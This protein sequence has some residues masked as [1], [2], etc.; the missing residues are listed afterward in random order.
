MQR[1]LS[2]IRARAHLEMGASDAGLALLELRKAEPEAPNLRWPSCRCACNSGQLPQAMALAELALK[3]E[4][5]SAEAR[6]ARAW[7]CRPGRDPKAAEA[8]DQVL[9]VDPTTWEA[10]LVRLQMHA[11]QG[12]WDAVRASLK[13]VPTA[14]AADPRV[15]YFHA[16]DAAQRGDSKALTTHLRKIA[17]QIDA[18]PEALLRYR[19]QMLLLTGLA[20][21]GL[22]ELDAAKRASR[23]TATA[24]AARARPRNCWPSSTS[25]QKQTDAGIAALEAHLRARPTDAKAL[26]LLGQAAVCRPAA[27]GRHADARGSGRPG[28]PRV[29]GRAGPEPAAH[30][31]PADALKALQAAVRKEPARI[32]FGLQLAEALLDTGD[33]KGAQARSLTWPDASPLTPACPCCKAASA[34]CCAT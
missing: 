23:S 14:K 26:G 2:L 17:E 30:G 7:C 6:F 19:P 16:Q 29:P 22:G 28:P 4:P 34:C 31:P 20:H 8:F 3:R 9:A 18:Q 24:V 21:F 5:Q 27:T 15:L 32:E 1:H 12:E 25:N 13:L 11:A 33:A 10:R